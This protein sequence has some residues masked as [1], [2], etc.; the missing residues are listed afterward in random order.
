[1]QHNEEDP[2]KRRA[3]I[4]QQLAPYMALG[5]QLAASV[6]VLGGIGWLTDRTYGTEPLGIVVGLCVGCVVG[7]VQ[8]LRSVQQLLSKEQQKKK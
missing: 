3:A 6:L 2:S 1:M 7:F 8:F 5:S 4:V